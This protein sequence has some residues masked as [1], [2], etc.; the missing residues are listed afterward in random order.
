MCL[1]VF[2]SILL[3]GCE[4]ETTTVSTGETTGK[5]TEGAQ[6]TQE[7]ED[8]PPAT[9]P[10]PESPSPPPSPPVVQEINCGIGAFNV[11]NC[12]NEAK[13]Q[14]S[15]SG[16]SHALGSPYGCTDP[17]GNHFDCNVV[18]TR[19]GGFTLSCTKLLL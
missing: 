2:S 1:V 6:E 14:F 11:L 17:Q 3:A 19:M 10:T 15:C 16:D 8:V 5:S 9:T 4:S 18:E 12:T 7:G 13:E